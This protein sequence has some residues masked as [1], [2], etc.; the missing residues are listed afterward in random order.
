MLQNQNELIEKNLKLTEETLK[1]VKKIHRQMVMGKVIGFLIL[2]IFVILP[3]VLGFIY[4]PPLITKMLKGYQGLIEAAGNT[5]GPVELL[6][7]IP[8]IGR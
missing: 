4:L 5:T 1:L 7:N 8:S 3:I 2:F 6:R